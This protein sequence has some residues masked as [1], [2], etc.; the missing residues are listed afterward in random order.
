MEYARDHR[1]RNDAMVATYCRAMRCGTAETSSAYAYSCVSKI[2]QAIKR[3]TAPGKWKDLTPSPEASS[4]KNSSWGGYAGYSQ[5]PNGHLWEIAWNHQWSVD[6]LCNA[7]GKTAAT[8]C[9]TN[10]A[11]P[12]ASRR[13]TLQR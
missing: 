5:D 6:W 1:R 4:K 8:Q 12:D 9:V 10:R 2:V 7:A 3:R 11:G 13:K